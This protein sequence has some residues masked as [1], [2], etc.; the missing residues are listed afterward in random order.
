[1]GKEPS[2]PDGPVTRSRSVARDRQTDRW[3]DRLFEGTWEG[4]LGSHLVSQDVEDLILKCFLSGF[5]IRLH[6]GMLHSS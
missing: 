1:M 4:E 5:C 3:A 2:F 6:S